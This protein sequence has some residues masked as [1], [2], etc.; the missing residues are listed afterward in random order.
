MEG[1]NAHDAWPAVIK[2]AVL[3]TAAAGG[4]KFCEKPAARATWH[5]GCCGHASHMPGPRVSFWNQ[6]CHCH[7]SCLPDDILLLGVFAFLHPSEL[8]TAAQVCTRWRFL[9][10]DR[11]L[12]RSIDLAAF[13]R[14]AK[15]GGGRV[16]DRALRALAAR[17]GAHCEQLRLCNFRRL[18][19]DAVKH[20]LA[21]APALTHLHLCNVSAVTDA[22]LF[23]LAR[24]AARLR[25]LSLFGCRNITDAGVAAVLA[26]AGSSLSEL[27]LRGCVRVTDA[28]LG[29][30]GPSATEVNLSGCALITAEGI[31]T[32]SRRCPRLQ[33]LNLH[34]VRVTDA[35]V[36][37]LVAAC[38]RLTT[39]NLGSANPYG[40]SALLTDAALS[41]LSRCGDLTC[42]SLQGASLVTDAGLAALVRAAPRIRRLN[43]A[44][45]YRLTDA[46]V[47][48]LG[49]RLPQLSHLSLAQ[50]FR[51]SDNALR[52]LGSAARALRHLDV[53]NCQGLTAASVAA[54]LESDAPRAVEREK[55]QATSS[56]DDDDG[57]GGGD[58]EDG[59]AEASYSSLPAAAE[60]LDED[61]SAGQPRRPAR[62]RV[63]AQFA[64]FS[65]LESLDIDGCRAISPEAV[66]ALR[67]G[68][69]ELAV[70]CF[71]S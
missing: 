20:A 6:N 43:L 65:A 55:E 23:E 57:E 24:G 45:C 31:A 14:V 30:L 39:L 59:N 64:L 56:G 28:A 12:W 36:A 32:L 70:K 66:A 26:A 1:A 3:S 33:R 10:Y 51:V 34:G 29:A 54:L 40:G 41:S 62:R 8:L 42:L 68:R 25:V 21:R 52:A 19:E 4:D 71:T 17:F 69:P 38:P 58:G 15:K 67:A 60:S 35:S 11:V 48:E 53:H 13:A 2:P 18:S 61:E 37:A 22:S 50:C 7:F 9:A 16:G 63:R 27:S 49:E 5:G 47:S 44:G 46:S